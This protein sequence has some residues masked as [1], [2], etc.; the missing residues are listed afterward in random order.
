MF[1][2]DIVLCGTLLAETIILALEPLGIRLNV[3]LW[4]DSQVVLFSI[5]RPDGHP[6]PFIT[7]RIKHIRAFN[8]QRAATWK[9]VPTNQN[10]AD[11]LSRGAS[12]KEFEKLSSLWKNGSVWLPDRK[13]WPTW[14]VSQ[15]KASQTLQILQLQC[16]SSSPEPPTDI[17]SVV[18]ISRYRWSSLMHTTAFIFRL[19]DN[20]KLKDRSRST[21]NRQLLAAVEVLRAE[22][23]WILIFQK[24]LLAN[25]IKY[26]QAKKKSWRP[27]LVSQLDFFLD[28]DGIVRCGGR[29]KNA[30]MSESAKY[31]ILVPKNTEL[32][33]LLIISVHERI[34][35]S[36]VDSTI[37]QL[38][39][40][41]WITSIRQ[42]VKDIE[43]KCVKCR[44]ISGPAYK[45]PDPAPLPAF[46]V[47]PAYLLLWE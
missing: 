42:Q 34:F 10:P 47:Q 30:A 26:L 4:S 22:R 7:N 9:Y 35:H 24:R 21:W 20:F 31:P 43:Q 29:F 40:R 3:F 8:H 39:Q 38:Q 41:Y 13:Q 45:L 25:E 5:S 12:L 16:E 33:R 37:V 14:S 1:Y 32:A 44:R 11:I 28:S 36:G 19:L 46:R 17:S 15:F 27:P 2:G 18:D 23:L 6:R